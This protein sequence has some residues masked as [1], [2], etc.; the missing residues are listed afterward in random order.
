LVVFLEEIRMGGLE[1]IALELGEQKVDTS[2][3]GDPNEYVVVDGDLVKTMEDVQVIIKLLNIIGTRVN[4]NSQ[5]AGHLVRPL[6]EQEKIML[7]YRHLDE[8][9]KAKTEEGNG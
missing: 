9:R 4:A 1:D 3:I 6:E 8:E 2:T 5:G 7:A